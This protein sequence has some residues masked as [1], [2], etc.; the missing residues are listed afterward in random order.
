[1]KQRWLRISLLII[2][3][4]AVIYFS[5]PAPA[6][7]VFDHN[8]PPVPQEAGALMQYVQQREAAHRLKPDNEARIIWH[9]TTHRKTPYAV[10]YLHG[11]SASQKEGDPVHLDFARRFGCNLYLS[12]LDGHG[13]DT[14]DPLLHMTAAGLWKD[15]EAALS[16]GKALGDKVILMTT[17]TGGTL[18]LMLAAAYP[19]DVYALINMSPNIAIND[20]LAFLVN[21]HWGLQLARLVS[22]GDFRQTREEDPVR[23]QYWNSDYRLEAVVQLQNLLEAGM[24]AATFN[25]IHQPVLNMYY[26]K[27][28]QHQDPTV[29]VS[30]IL[31]MTQQLGTPDS[32]KIAVPIPGA[33]GHVLGSSLIS[34]D[35]PAVERTVN[36]FAQEKLKMIPVQ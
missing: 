35:I 18:G 29:R 6:S 22:K 13:I 11:F 20:K 14:S 32:L 10:V 17:S 9:D 26:Y 12:R 25:K 2:A 36:A 4:L 1:M 27:D 15:A 31:Q 16:V 5:G 33:G 24:H 23:A 34:K 28:A 30:A 3:V 19:N 7:P 21:D 8:L